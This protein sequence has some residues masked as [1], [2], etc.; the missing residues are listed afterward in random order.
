MGRKS[1]NPTHLV[2]A[3]AAQLLHHASAPTGGTRMSVALHA[4][5]SANPL[6]SGTQLAI[7]PVLRVSLKVGSVSQPPQLFCDFTSMELRPWRSVSRT[8]EHVAWPRPPRSYMLRPLFFPP[9]LSCLSVG[10]KSLKPLLW[11]VSKGRSEPPWSH[12]LA[13]CPIWVRIRI[14]GAS[15]NLTEGAQTVG[16][17]WNRS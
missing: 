16:G 2:L 5:A 4:L 14:S 7:T 12:Q 15:P 8:P 13:A 11:E 17:R 1:W 9:L 3:R 10:T 6:A